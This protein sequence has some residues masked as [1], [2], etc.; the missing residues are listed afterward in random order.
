[1]STVKHPDALA[2]PLYGLY[3][4]DDVR[5][6][7]ILN[8]K[9]LAQMSRDYDKAEIQRIREALEWAAEH[10]DYDFAS[11]LPNL[12]YTNVDIHFYLLKVLER[13]RTLD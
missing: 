1:M 13:M 4:I 12:R 3:Y 5:S 6:A 10:T 8:D 9:N 2:I 7:D 11:I